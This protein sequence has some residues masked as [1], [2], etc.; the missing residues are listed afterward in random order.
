LRRCCKAHH[1]RRGQQ[2]QIGGDGGAANLQAVIALGALARCFNPA[3][4]TA[5]ASLQIE[6]DKVEQRDGVA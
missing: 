4:E 2:N 5:G 1:E 6:L 3:T